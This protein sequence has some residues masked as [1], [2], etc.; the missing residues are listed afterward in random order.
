VNEEHFLTK[1]VAQFPGLLKSDALGTT[2]P[3]DAS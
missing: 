3:G 2:T 1:T